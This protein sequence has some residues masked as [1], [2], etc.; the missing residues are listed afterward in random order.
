VEGEGIEVRV[1]DITAKSKIDLLEQDFM[2]KGL[3]E[4]PLFISIEPRNL[5]AGDKARLFIIEKS[6]S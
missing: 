6:N 5:Q 2:I 3:V 4:N 1:F